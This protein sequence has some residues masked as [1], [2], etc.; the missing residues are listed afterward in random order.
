MGTRGK[1]DTYTETAL[2]TVRAILIRERTDDLIVGVRNGKGRGK[3]CAGRHGGP[4]EEL[5]GREDASDPWV[6][7]AQ[8]RRSKKEPKCTRANA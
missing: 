8:L 3:C 2:S 5:S 1:A 4:A 6:G 7:A